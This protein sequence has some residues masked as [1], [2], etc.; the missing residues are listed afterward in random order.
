MEVPLPFSVAII[1]SHDF[2]V[3]AAT[4][5]GYLPTKLMLMFPH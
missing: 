4:T 5:D 2:Y 3:V 1:A